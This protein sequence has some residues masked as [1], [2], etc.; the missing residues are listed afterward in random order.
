MIAHTIYPHLTGDHTLATVSG[1]II[2]GLLRGELGFSGAITSD[3]L[4]MTGLIREYEIIDA[5]KLALLAG[6]T[7]LLLRDEG[8]LVD[9][10]YHGLVTAIR[11][12]EIPQHV[13]DDAICRNLAVKLEYGMFE[14]GGLADPKVA[15]AVQGDPE[16]IAVERETAR[17][18]VV[19]SSPSGRIPSFPTEAKIL[20]VEQVGAAQFTVNNFRC[21]P[22]NLWEAMLAHSRN[23]Y[24]VEI[25]G[26]N[27]AGPEEAERVFRRL[28]EADVIVATNYQ[29]TRASKP[30]HAFIRKIRE[31]I[32]DKP[33]I[34][35]T[36]A[37]YQPDG[38]IATELC[39][40][41]DN[42]ESLRA[43]ADVIYG[44]LEPS[45]ALPLVAPPPP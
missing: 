41:A 13:I 36:N 39:L 1:K 4:L 25:D 37:P 33:L 15:D 12:G 34:V 26:W 7:L 30:N 40:F 44:K 38:D 45:G 8:P 31:R 42:P 23:V 5:C 35:L 32:G 19:L 14:N 27:A 21:H 11:S 9:E 3:N 10:I 18:S 2:T 28:G 24:C 17:K 20:L 22:G 43:A 6:M 16:A 29:T